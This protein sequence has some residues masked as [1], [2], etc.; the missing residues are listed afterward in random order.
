[1]PRDEREVRHIAVLTPQGAPYLGRWWWPDE[2]K[3][4]VGGQLA[5]QDEVWRLTLFGWLGPWDRKNSEF[6]PTL[7]HGEIG[8]SP[9][10]AM[11]LVPAG[12]SAHDPQPPHETHCGLNTVLVGGHVD[13]SLRVERAQLG[14]HN[15]NEWANRQPWTMNHEGPSDDEPARDTVTFT[16]PEVKTTE[17]EGTKISLERTWQQQS[18]LSMVKTESHEALILTFRTPVD[19][20]ELLHDWVRPFLGLLELA[21][22]S[23]SAI[24]DLTI[25]TPGDDDLRTG[26][27]VLSSVS[28]RSEQPVR[29]WFQMLF[30]LSDVGFESFVPGFLALHKELGTVFDLMT[31][32]KGR[33]YVSNQFM[34]AASAVEAYHRRQFGKGKASKDHK[35]LL[36]RVVS[37]APPADQAWL[38]EQLRF[39]HEPTFAERI[40][41][42]IERAG[43]LFPGLVGNVAKWSKWVKD[44]RNSIA[45]RDPTML[46]IDGQ[47]RITI[48]VTETIRWL[49]VLTLLRDLGINDEVIEARV[50]Q[51]RGLE[52]AR[53]HLKEAMPDW[54]G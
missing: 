52:S 42:V 33:G 46:D 30:L 12:W 22:N 19:L 37:A 28:R 13:G 15:L 2:P 49:L 14:L 9:I 17:F 8:G 20:E 36:A 6:V 26:L 48:R 35:E 10:T 50:R 27:N 21:A 32:I 38:K 44:G 23:P 45:H 18:G 34:A 31:A 51:E 53:E 25:W 41:A 4:I 7:L 29:N 54:F 3:H 1:M 24:L 11:D 47:W 43:P 40:N 16:P 39:S 5:L